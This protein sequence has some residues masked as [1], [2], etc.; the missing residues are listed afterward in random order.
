MFRRGGGAGLGPAYLARVGP[1]TGLACD[2]C[3]GDLEPD[4]VGF[5]HCGKR[6]RGLL[7]AMA[8]AASMPDGPARR[9]RLAELGV[10]FAARRVDVARGRGPGEVMRATA[11]LH[12]AEARA[13]ELHMVGGDAA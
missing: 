1:V 10:I 6:C 11:E 2:A 9:A 8:R 13:A 4:R 5:G 7:R 3:G 12:A